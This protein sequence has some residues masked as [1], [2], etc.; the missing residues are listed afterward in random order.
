MEKILNKKI[1]ITI[2]LI[3]IIFSVVNTNNVYALERRSSPP[4][5]F[6]TKSIEDDPP[7]VSGDS[8]PFNFDFIGRLISIFQTLKEFSETDPRLIFPFGGKIEKAG[9][10][11]AITFR[12]WFLVV[13][14]DVG[15][16]M[17]YPPPF[18]IFCP[19]PKIPLGGANILVGDPKGS[20]GDMFTLPWI[21]DIYEF[22]KQ[23]TVGVWALGTAFGPFPIERV[24]EILDEI[25]INLASPGSGCPGFSTYGPYI[26]YCFDN[27]KLE[28]SEDNRNVILKI[29]T[30]E[31]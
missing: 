7:E 16:P 28:C 5:G 6:D 19:K 10:G 8:G 25:S 11:C 18:C 31:V 20:P 22:K 3:L 2:I 13:L 15:F 24:N 1:I 9:G 29:G 12:F 27:F 26:P 30:S 17:S 14:G 23:G 4:P 21:T